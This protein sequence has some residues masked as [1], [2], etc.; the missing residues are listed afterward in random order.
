MKNRKK[1]LSLIVLLLIA[2]GIDVR[3]YI[4]H[5]KGFTSDE[6]I[7]GFE[8]SARKVLGDDLQKVSET[9]VVATFIYGN[10]KDEEHKIYYH[11]LQTTYHEGGNP[12]SV[13]GL[14]TDALE[15]LFSP[16]SADSCEEM[17]INEWHG[18]L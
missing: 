13:T 12:S 3:L 11:I 10:E 9:K 18:S 1:L 15:V 17:M 7:E 6:V 8:I 14:N 5:N 4:I 2:A 16:G